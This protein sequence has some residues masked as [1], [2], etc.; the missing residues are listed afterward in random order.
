MARTRSTLLTTRRPAIVPLLQTDTWLRRVRAASQDPWTSPVAD[1]LFAVLARRA[2]KLASSSP[3]FDCLSAAE[4]AGAFP[5]E[6]HPLLPAARAF[7][8]QIRTASLDSHDGKVL[9]F[10]ARFPLQASALLVPQFIHIAGGILGFP[11]VAGIP[12]HD[13]LALFRDDPDVLRLAAPE[14]RQ[15]FKSAEAPLTGRMWRVDSNG[16]RGECDL[17]KGSAPPSRAAVAECP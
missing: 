13:S 7:W 2:A 14:I 11:F 12:S 6:P 9:R 10:R 17:G 8:T 4:V 1:G 15:Q 16:I 5:H 3:Q